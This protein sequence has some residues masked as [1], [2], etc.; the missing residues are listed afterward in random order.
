M[1]VAFKYAN[2]TQFNTE[3]SIR[4]WLYSIYQN[5]RADSWLERIKLLPQGECL[6]MI[7]YTIYKVKQ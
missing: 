5:E 7:G 6:E 1:I 2:A 3:E 4:Q